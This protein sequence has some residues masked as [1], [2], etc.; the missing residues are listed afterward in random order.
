MYRLD[1]GT[2]GAM[3]PRKGP[4]RGLALWRENGRDTLF[5]ISP[6]YQLIALD[7]K[8]GRPVGA[9]GAAGI[10]DLKLA[11]NEQ[12]DPVNSPIGASS[13]PVVVNGVVIVG[14]AFAAGAAPPTK[15]MP[16]GGV[17]GFDARTGQRLWTFRTIAPTGDPGATTWPGV[18]ARGGAHQRLLW[19][20]PSRQQSVFQQPGLHRC[21]HGRAPLVFPACA[22]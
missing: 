10:V 5:I 2:R 14:S 20:A 8:S 17:M 16:A 9:F 4:G 3:A 13:P 1:E 6:G 19:R 18:L 12:L 7:A 21:A 22:P 11:L 15:E